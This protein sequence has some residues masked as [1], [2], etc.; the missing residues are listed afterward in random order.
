MGLTAEMEGRVREI[1]AA[2]RAARAGGG[3]ARS[4]SIAQRCVRCAVR[5]HCDEALG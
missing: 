5:Q 2:I 3:V 1:V 4:H